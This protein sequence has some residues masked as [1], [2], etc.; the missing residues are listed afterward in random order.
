MDEG[1]NSKNHGFRDLEGQSLRQQA[2]VAVEGPPPAK[3]SVAAEGL[4]NVRFPAAPDVA[5]YY[6]RRVQQYAAKAG[7]TPGQW[8]GIPAAGSKK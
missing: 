6:L 7:Q 8:L 5:S 2:R 4:E 3:N 1:P